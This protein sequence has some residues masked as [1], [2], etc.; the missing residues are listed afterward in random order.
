MV[1]ICDT[2]ATESFGGKLANM[3]LQPTSGRHRAGEVESVV[4]AARG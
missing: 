1:M 4:N 2:L 3:P